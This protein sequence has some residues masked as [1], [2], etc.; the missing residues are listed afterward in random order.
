MSFYKEIECEHGWTDELD[1]DHCNMGSGC[2]DDSGCYCTKDDCPIFDDNE[3]P[4]LNLC[5]MTDER[6]SDE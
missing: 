3:V 6:Q 1:F 2:G 4:I 5:H